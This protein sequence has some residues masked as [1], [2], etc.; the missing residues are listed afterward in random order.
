MGFFVSVVIKRYFIIK[1]K[2]VK[3]KK[4]FVFCTWDIFQATLLY[5][6]TLNLKE[7]L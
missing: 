6:P 1:G 4:S 3:I 2:F 5:D 7:I